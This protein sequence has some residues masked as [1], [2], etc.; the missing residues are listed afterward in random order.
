ITH[1]TFGKRETIGG[2]AQQV[3]EQ[4]LADPISKADPHG[5]ARKIMDTMG[6]SVE[7]T[8]AVHA[9]LQTLGADK[10]PG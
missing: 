5:L 8:L 7:R 1:E 9:L 2:G 3:L 4:L 10:E 6:D